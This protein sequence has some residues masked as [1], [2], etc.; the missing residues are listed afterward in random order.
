VSLP[1]AAR[2]ELQ[3]EVRAAIRNVVS[4]ML[5][6][7]QVVRI[8]DRFITAYR[9]AMMGKTGTRLKATTYDIM[10]LAVGE[11][12]EVEASCK[13]NLHGQ[14]K[15]IRRK[16]NEPDRKW[17]VEQVRPGVWRVERRPDGA[18][19]LQKSAYRNPKAVFLAALTVGGA[20][21]TYPGLAKCHQ[22]L[23]CHTKSKARTL[24]G[25]VTADWSGK[26]TSQG[27]T[28]RRTK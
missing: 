11:E 17:R 26:T 25:D 8:T 20:A 10:A 12:I 15:T 16:L 3:D 5:P 22:I 13:A 19:N 28:I 23:N 9:R 24:T 4:V 27:V 2:Q 7:H 14:F 1:P 21:R 18:W 6:D